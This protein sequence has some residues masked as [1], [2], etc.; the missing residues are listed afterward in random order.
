VRTGRESLFEFDP[1][2]LAGLKEYL[3]LVSKEWDQALGRLK[4][5]VED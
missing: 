2:P 1:Q 4:R 5:F 3:A